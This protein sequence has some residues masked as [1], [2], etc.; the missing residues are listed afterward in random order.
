MVPL[1]S[2]ILLIL[3][4]VALGATI[5]GSNG[6]AELILLSLIAILLWGILV[7]VDALDK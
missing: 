3:L 2:A 1:A 6:A 4:A 7:C 5:A